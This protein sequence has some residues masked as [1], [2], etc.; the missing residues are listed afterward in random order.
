M[1]A[2]DVTITALDHSSA[3]LSGAFTGGDPAYSNYR[4]LRVSIHYG[5]D[6]ALLYV[7]SQESSGAVS[8]FSETISGLSPGGYTWTAA[9]QYY[10]AQGWHDAGYTDSGSFVI[11]PDVYVQAWIYD[12]G[13]H[14]AQPWV[15][16]GGWHRAQAW[17]HDGDWR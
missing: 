4:R 14:R 1:A 10:D 8:T 17:V 13:W 15:Y 2:L 16:N 6:I 3:R 11:T 12:G 7:Q 9:L 5:Q